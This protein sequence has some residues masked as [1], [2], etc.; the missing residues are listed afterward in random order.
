MFA[1][2]PPGARHTAT[3][4]KPQVEKLVGSP[5]PIGA[6]LATA[7]APTVVVDAIASAVGI[8]LS[9]R[10]RVTTMLSIG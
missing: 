5:V 2:E 3:G 7:V 4:N 1:A 8:R 10:V 9:T 6:R